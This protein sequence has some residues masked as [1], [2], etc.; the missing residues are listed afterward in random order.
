MTSPSMRWVPPA[1]PYTDAILTVQGPLPMDIA[2]EGLLHLK[3]LRSPHAHARIK[4]I[5]KT[6]AWRSGRRRGLYWRGASRLYAP[7]AEDHLVVSR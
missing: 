5:D 7:P 1:N 3:V 2:L 6:K 4:S